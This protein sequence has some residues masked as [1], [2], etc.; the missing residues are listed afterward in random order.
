MLI[1]GESDYGVY[2]NSLYALCDFSVN[3]KRFQIK[4]FIKKK[5]CTGNTKFLGN[6]SES[7]WSGRARADGKWEEVWMKQD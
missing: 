2:G 7:I 4:R 6:C 5:R 1:T 3:L